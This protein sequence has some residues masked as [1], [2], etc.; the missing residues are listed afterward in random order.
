MSILRRVLM[1]SVCLGLPVLAGANQAS[2]AASGL[3]G[4]PG[5][6]ALISL[7]LFAVL[8]I[9]AAINGWKLYPRIFRSA[10]DEFTKS[11]WELFKA[12]FGFSVV[13]A[14]VVPV[15]AGIAM[16]ALAD[17]KG[18]VIAGMCAIGIPLFGDVILGLV[19]KQLMKLE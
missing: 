4:L 18:Q 7:I 16:Q 12:R 19:A 5:W 1:I 15:L 6:V 9:T 8:T 14:I 2:P 11:R 10:A 3:K 17:G 13:W